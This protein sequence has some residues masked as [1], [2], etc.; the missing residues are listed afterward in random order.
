MKITANAQ[1]AQT[2]NANFL[3]TGFTGQTDFTVVRYSVYRSTIDFVS[4]VTQS[5]PIV[6][7][8]VR[9][10]SL[11]RF[12]FVYLDFDTLCT[13]KF[14]SKFICSTQKI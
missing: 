3:E 13:V 4:K 1:E 10:M 7:D 12:F 5:R 14:L 2:Q 6:Y 8:K 9:A 11:H